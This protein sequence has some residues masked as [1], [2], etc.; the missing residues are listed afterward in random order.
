MKKPTV[1]CLGPEFS[2]SHVAAMQK[3]PGASFIFC[4]PHTEVLK[5]FI[6][7]EGNFALVPINNTNEGPVL[8]ILKGIAKVM[9]EGR[10]IHLIGRIDLPIRHCFAKKNRK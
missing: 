8:P 4:S 1:L 2:Y 7:G 9:L 3:F 5:R 6:G 10:S